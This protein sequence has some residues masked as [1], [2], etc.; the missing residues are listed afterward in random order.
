MIPQT[1]KDWTNCIVN[2]CKINLTKDFAQ[3]RLAVYQD[4]RNTETQKFI[5]LYG[6]Q[7]LN[8]IIQWFNQVI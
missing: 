5:S 2:D 8:N 6:E 4:K 3:Q 7:H 1:F